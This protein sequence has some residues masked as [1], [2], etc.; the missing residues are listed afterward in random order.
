MQM[1]RMQNIELVQKLQIQEKKC[2]KL[3]I[4]LGL[5]RVNCLHED[6]GIEYQIILDNETT[7]TVKA[8]KYG[9]KNF[10]IQEVEPYRF[11]NI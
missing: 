11:G 1:V 6:G 8:G 7:L 4:D 2:Q 10:T 5:T 3:Y 9:N